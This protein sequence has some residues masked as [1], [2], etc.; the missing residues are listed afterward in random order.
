M[1]A[2]EELKTQRV[3]RMLPLGGADQ[4]M[5]AGRRR[6]TRRT[7]IACACLGVLSIATGVSLTVAGGSNTSMS[8][9]PAGTP[10]ANVL[11]T[12]D[13][14]D[15]TWL[16]AN[17]RAD[18]S[19]LQPNVPE[20]APV[21][22]YQEFHAAD[23]GPATARLHSSVGLAMTV[24]RGSA[25][26]LNSAE[27]DRAALVEG[28]KPSRTTV[29]G[30]RALLLQQSAGFLGSRGALRLLWTEQS[31]LTIEID[32]FG[33]PSLDDAKRLAKSLVVHPSPTPPG[34]TAAAVTQIRSAFRTA[35]SAPNPPAV[36][37][38]AVED[39]STVASTL[40][41][42][43]Q[44]LPDSVRSSRVSVADIAFLGPDEALVDASVSYH[45]MGSGV[46]NSIPQTAKLLEG[47]WRVSRESFCATIG[48]SGVHCPSFP[49]G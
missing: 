45:W 32:A 37:L 20:L 14:V 25:I 8:V 46:V 23:R 9:S 1:N 10:A 11:A 39:G 42:V 38:G 47:R 26:D 31:G 22:Y 15:V 35:Y 18:N 27:K 21:S 34:Q 19:V 3:D 40:Q 6:R 28:F 13:G 4:A 5:A 33:G 41:K 43:T 2:L 49:S 44:L 30:R 12:V 16:P 48:A 36:A 7:V 17:Y 29:R 24:V